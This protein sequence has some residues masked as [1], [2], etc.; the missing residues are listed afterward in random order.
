VIHRAA[1]SHPRVTF[2]VL[3]AS[4]FSYSVLQSLVAPVLATIAHD[5]HTTEN[6]V[7]WVLTAY[8]L[9]ASVFTPILGRIGDMYGKERVFV[10]TLA[11]LATGS[12]VAALAPNITVMIVARSIQGV[13]GAIF[14]L[15]FGI[16][17]DEFP[18]ERVAGTVG[19]LAALLGVGSG[20]G[21][22][23]AG[24]IVNALDYHWLFWFPL[25]VVVPAAVAAW[26]LIP[27]SPT[28]AATGV[29]W[30]GAG[31][32][33]AWLIALLMGVSEGP[34]WGWASP[35]VLGLLGASVVLAV[36][37][38]AAE[39]RSA[40]PVIDMRMMRLPVVWRTNVVALLFGAGMFGAY[41]F[42]PQYV[43]TPSAAGYG[44]GLSITESGLLMLPSSMTMLIIG[45][46]A[47]PLSRRF[48][49]GRVTFGG[50]LMMASAFVVVALATHDLALVYVA[51]AMLGIGVGLAFATTSSLI[52][53]A[54]PADQTGVASGMNTNI[55]TI[56]GAIGTGIASSLITA[57]L[58]PTGYPYAS[59]YLNGWILLAALGAGGAAV[60]LTIPKRVGRRAPIEAVVEQPAGVAVGAPVLA[61]SGG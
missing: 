30:T 57:H 44:F 45:P 26:L 37:W 48:G 52:V 3:G 46:S 28:R 40:S 17:R 41:A 49:S 55:R 8:L 5:L 39:L 12:L 10:L 1:Q 53:A 56:G 15:G 20:I 51:V 34:A 24:P 19:A 14:P 60:A 54:V 23:L 9:S 50:A 29:N 47:A 32:L 38:I 61:E 27:E 36:V 35:A 11:A 33:A 59:G 7:T 18:A 31:L 13:G 4:F 21:I 42:L 16:V 58:H 43:Q 22:V 6:T 2:V 25:M